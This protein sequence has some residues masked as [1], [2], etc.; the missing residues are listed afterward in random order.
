VTWIKIGQSYNI[1]TALGK[2]QEL[3]K[4]I[5]DCARERRMVGFVQL[6][7][8]QPECRPISSTESAQ[9]IRIKSD[10][11]TGGKNKQWKGCRKKRT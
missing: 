8:S 9:E 2:K 11:D 5:V 6:T 7:T 10:T 1:S 4:I 3:K